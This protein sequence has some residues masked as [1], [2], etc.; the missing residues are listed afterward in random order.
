MRAF[1]KKF[2]KIILLGFDLTVSLLSLYAAFLLRFEG[3]LPAA[4]VEVF[5]DLAPIV[6]LCRAL[7]FALCRFYSRFWEYASWEDLQQVLKAAV[8]GTVMVLIFMFMYNRAHL[9]SRSVLFMDLILVVL[10]LG[11]SRLIWKLLTDRAN[12][13]DHSEGKGRI[14][15]LILGAGYTGV[16]LLKHLRRFSPHYSVIG[17]LDDDPK[18]L[19]HQVMGVKVLGG[20]KDLPQLKEAL[21]IQEV[22]MAVTSIDAER[23][24]AMVNVCRDCNVKYKTVSSFF[25]LATHQP[26]ISKIR[27]IEISDLLGREPVYLD[28]SMIQK[29]VGGKK[30]MVTGA[31][32]S[33]GSELCRQLLEYDPAMLIMID[34][35]E[36]YLYDL[37]MELNAEK[38]NAE[39]KYFFLSVTHEKK[40][41]VLFQRFRPQL[42]FH[43]AAHKHVPL[44][45]E[46][47]DE[48]VL[49]NVQGTRVTADLSERYGVEKFIL[50]STDKVVRPTSVM[51]MTKKIAERYIQYKAGRSK[52]DF[53]TVRFGNV[54]GSNGSVVPLFQKQ[55]ERGGP[56]T[57]THPEME[58]FFMLIPEAV[59]LILQAATIG[60]GGEILMLE[61]GHPV[62][63]MALAE[64]MIRLLGYTLGEN[65]QIQITGVRPG[66][67]L[68]EELVDDGED[69]LDTLHKKIKRL[70]SNNAPSE[71]FGAKI[72]ALVHGM[73]DLEV[74]AARQ[75]LKDFIQDECGQPQAPSPLSRKS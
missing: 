13:K 72:D 2:R 4:Q 44:M 1:N 53:M 6:L 73:A 14:P 66:E 11:S 19:D 27:N 42:V 71:K 34:K 54:L 26:H 8:M 56:V 58:R 49:N 20:H 22:L 28:L 29:M 60:K 16:N 45:E 30:I 46:N 47:A 31:G 64:K 5:F 70:C 35:C 61:M 69:V 7:S 63:L 17:F 21:G 18:K 62:K 51:G 57:V 39:R 25:D 37:N 67:K 59:Q 38:T 41:D 24:E 3:A 10:M 9:V 48:A 74:A 15:I 33:I 40:L 32:G 65:M 55:I 36:N 23:L 12:R 50:V 75:R 52:T 68:S 43:A